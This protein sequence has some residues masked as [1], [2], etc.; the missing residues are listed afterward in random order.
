MTQDNRDQPDVSRRDLG[1]LLG[2]LG[3]AAGLAALASCSSEGNGAGAPE[4]MASVAQAWATGDAGASGTSV[5][6]V[7]TIIATS[8]TSLRT[9]AGT[10]SGSGTGNASTPV[11]IVGGYGAPADGGG[12]VFYWS[13]DTTTPDDGGTVIV[14]SGARTGCWKR[15]YSGALAAAWFGARGN[16]NYQDG[17]GRWYVDSGHT[18][19]ASDDTSALNTA[20]AAAVSLGGGNV[21]LP[22]RHLISAQLTVA[23]NNITLSGAPGLTTVVAANNTI[24]TTSSSGFI[25]ANDVSFFTMRDVVVDANQ[26]VLGQPAARVQ[27]IQLVNCND[28]LFENVRLQNFRGVSNGPV[29]GAWNNTAT[30]VASSQRIR[31]TNC[32]I[33]NCGTNT[34][35]NGDLCDG[36]Y[37]SGTQVIFDGCTCTSVSGCAFVLQ[38]ACDSGIVGCT[39]TTVGQGAGINANAGYTYYGNFVTGLT[40]DGYYATVPGAFQIGAGSLTNFTISGLIIRNALAAGPGIYVI[41]SAGQTPAN[42]VFSACIVDIAGGSGTQAFLCGAGCNGIS[43]IGGRFTSSGTNAIEFVGPNSDIIVSGAEIA[44]ANGNVYAVYVGGSSSDV[45]ISNCDIPSALTGAGAIWFDGNGTSSNLRCTGNLIPNTPTKI[46][47]PGSTV[48][49]LEYLNGSKSWSPGAISNASAA[50]TSVTVAGANTSDT[51]AVAY[52]S[53][54]PA[55]CFLAGQV[56]ATN[57]V[58]VTIANLSGAS[59]TPAAGTLSVDVFQHLS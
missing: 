56:T 37:A 15:I 55:G 23:G 9:S 25:Y 26:F 36:F 48:N 49:V 3:G 51:V 30:A 7:D 19:A 28:C 20:I 1:A 53:A 12:G 57:T 54:L 11:A 43:I 22:G 18:I 52:S 27:G 46:Y 17:T 24:G 42:I 16:A 39:A 44:P 6:W 29:S 21:L 10:D 5:V 8:G 47:A 32:S 31:V 35:G 13:G 38:F 45:V 59:Q 4:K 58:T 2:V 50:T 40:I 34:G 41:S 14:P 33:V